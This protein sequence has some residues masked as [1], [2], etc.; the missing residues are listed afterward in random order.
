MVPK[1]S[2]IF[3]AAV[4]VLDLKFRTPVLTVERKHVVNRSSFVLQ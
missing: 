1:C 3:L 4:G 2:N